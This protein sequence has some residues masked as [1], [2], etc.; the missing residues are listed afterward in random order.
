MPSVSLLLSYVSGGLGIGLV[1]ALALAEAPA[2]RVVSA[3]A[4]VPALPVSLIWRPSARRQ[5]A[6]ARLASLLAGAGA[7]AGARLA[8]RSR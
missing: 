3:P 6:L 2:D 5:P 8:R 7:R 4:R 1:P